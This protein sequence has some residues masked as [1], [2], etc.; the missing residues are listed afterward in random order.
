[1]A[2]GK[3]TKEMRGVALLRREVLGQTLL[4]ADCSENVPSVPGL[5]VPGIYSR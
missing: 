3:E 1:M 2:K 5:L 4:R